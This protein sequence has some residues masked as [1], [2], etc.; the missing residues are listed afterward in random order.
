ML[1]FLAHVTRSDRK[2]EKRFKTLAVVRDML[3]TNFL[4]VSIDS[5]FIV[6]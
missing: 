1:S 5:F 2:T 6:L 3:N 4:R